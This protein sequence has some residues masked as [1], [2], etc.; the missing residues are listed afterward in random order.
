MQIEST[1]PRVFPAE[2]VRGLAA[3]PPGLSTL[4]F[5]EMWERFSYYGMRAILVLF[6]VAPAAAGGL[7]FVTKDA[8]SLYGTYTM[9]VYMLSVVGGV[10]ADRFLGAARAVFV[11]GIIIA[12]GH[13]S[14]AVHSLS[15]FYGGLG[16][17]AI[18]TGLL[19]P[20]ISTMV[21]SL[22]APGDPR[23]DS[24]FSLFYVGI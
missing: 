18:G 20:N 1:A 11:G 5:A 16:L 2:E 17:I 24:G 12:C 14:M 22:Y 15:F 7:G 4:F 6:M 10:V 13:F 19:K 9:L 23:R 8:A 3:H 21:G